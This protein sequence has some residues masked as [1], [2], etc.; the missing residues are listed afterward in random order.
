MY[1]NALPEVHD[2]ALAGGWAS[3]VMV[4]VTAG[5]PTSVHY[6]RRNHQTLP[7]KL[8]SQRHRQL[9]TVH[10]VRMTGVQNDWLEQCRLVGNLKL[11]GVV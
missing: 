2:H 1:L 8:P 11:L 7:S 4:L 5:P 9:Q 3:E 10:A 6:R